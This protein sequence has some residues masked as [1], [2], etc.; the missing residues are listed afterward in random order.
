MGRMDDVRGDRR[1]EGPGQVRMGDDRADGYFREELKPGG[2]R[3]GDLRA[4]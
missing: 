1:S 4:G 2:V 3:A